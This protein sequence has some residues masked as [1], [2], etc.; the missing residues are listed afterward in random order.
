[1]SPGNK[2]NKNDQF[3]NI[4]FNWKITPLKIIIF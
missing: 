4:K 3:K 2:Q 1:M